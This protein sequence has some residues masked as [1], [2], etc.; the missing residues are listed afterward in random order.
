MSKNAR[1]LS[2]KNKF[3]LIKQQFIGFK[4]AL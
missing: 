1:V 2:K 4:K 3:W